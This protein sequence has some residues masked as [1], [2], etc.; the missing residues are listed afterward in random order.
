[1]PRK[2]PI[3]GVEVMT[4]MEFWQ[5]EAEKE[6]RQVSDVLR[7]FYDEWDEDIRKQEEMYKNTLDQNNL[8]VMYLNYVSDIGCDYFQCVQDINTF[9][10]EIVELIDCNIHQSMRETTESFVIYAK[11]LDGEYRIITMT[12]YNW[13]GSFYEPPD[14]D[15]EIDVMDCFYPLRKNAD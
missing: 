6:G 4:H 8:Y 11:C 10:V 3:T 5:A 9:I 13:S 7:D 12:T 14:W 2:D 15:F 1:M